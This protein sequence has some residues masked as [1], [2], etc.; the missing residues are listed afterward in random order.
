MWLAE[1]CYYYSF[2]SF[3][4]NPQQVVLVMWLLCDWLQP[5]MMIDCWTFSR[6]YFVIAIFVIHSLFSYFSLFAS[7][8]M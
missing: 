3:L 8:G 5:K 1:V 4:G 2:K 6:A 7:E